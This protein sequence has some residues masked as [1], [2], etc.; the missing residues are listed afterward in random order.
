MRPSL[1]PRCRRRSRA[2]AGLRN[3]L[4]G[5]HRALPE[6]RGAAGALVVVELVAVPDAELDHRVLGARAEAAVALEA[7]AARE[8]AA[9]LED[10]LLSRE[11]SDDLAEVCDTLLGRLFGLLPPVGVAEVPQVELVPVRDIV[12]R[13]AH[14]GGAAQPG[15]DV[16]GRLLAVADADGDGALA[17]HHVPAREHPRA[18]GLE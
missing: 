7:V 3:H 13:R 16:T 8:A 6:A 18:A 15:V 9:R 1:Q 10:G 17:R 11:A 2:S 5:V 14:G 4:D 12:L